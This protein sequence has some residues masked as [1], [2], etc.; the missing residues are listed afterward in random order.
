[1]DILTIVFLILS[2]ILSLAFL[3][4][5]ANQ[6]LLYRAA[7]ED[8]EFSDTAHYLRNR[9]IMSGALAVNRLFL[10]F[11]VL[12]PHLPINSQAIGTREILFTIWLLNETITWYVWRK[13]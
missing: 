9:A 8:P 3:Y 4:T 5:A 7:E 1:M 12:I 6:R 10:A 13:T 2:F 11:L